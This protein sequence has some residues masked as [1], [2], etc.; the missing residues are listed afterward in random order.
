MIEKLDKIL[1]P[2]FKWMFKGSPQKSFT[3]FIVVWFKH[4]IFYFLMSLLLFP[5]SYMHINIFIKMA[6]GISAYVALMPAILSIDV[7]R[8]EK[9]QETN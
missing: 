3:S 5:I 4:L 1:G 6:F 9:D 7:R 8:R 2:F